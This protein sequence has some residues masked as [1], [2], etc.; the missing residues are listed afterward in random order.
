MENNKQEKELILN[1]IKSKYESKLIGVNQEG[2]K[3]IVS[4]RL[5]LNKDVFYL[6]KYEIIDHFTYEKKLFLGYEEEEFYNFLEELMKNTRFEMIDFLH[7][8]DI[9]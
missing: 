4:K 8:R 2:F 9:I 6:I 5:D 3:V 7:K 1:H